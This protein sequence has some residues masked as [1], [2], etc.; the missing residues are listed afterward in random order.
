MMHLSAF[1]VKIAWTMC[2]CL[3][4]HT[5]SYCN[6]P[7]RQLFL[8]IAS[9]S[10]VGSRHYDAVGFFTVNVACMKKPTVASFGICCSVVDVSLR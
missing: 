5:R 1:V 8:L 3:S 4:F 9:A 6:L 2:A 10:V 7:V